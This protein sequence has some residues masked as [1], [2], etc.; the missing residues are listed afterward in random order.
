MKCISG[1][2]YPVYS[3]IP[4][5]CGKVSLYGVI[6]NCVLWVEFDEKQK[7]GLWEYKLPR[8]KL[9]LH[10]Q[11]SVFLPSSLYKLSDLSW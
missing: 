2:L 1:P 3:H 5:H 8:V 4:G 7:K 9:E 6:Q 10:F 11:V